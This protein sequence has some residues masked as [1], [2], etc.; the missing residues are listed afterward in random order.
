MPRSRCTID[1]VRAPFIV[2]CIALLTLAATSACGGGDDDDTPTATAAGNE[3][4]IPSI[5]PNPDPLS[6]EEY[7]AVICSGLADYTAAIVTETTVEGIR[8]VVLDYIASL[9]AVT[10]PEDVQPFHDDFIAYLSAAID[11]PTDLLAMPRPLPEDDVRDRLA[12]KENDVE[13]CRNATY[14]AERAEDTG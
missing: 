7:L 9:Q 10:P 2:A 11:S 6:D 14:F 12:G 13:E 1:A 3:T 4:P 8:A 5:T